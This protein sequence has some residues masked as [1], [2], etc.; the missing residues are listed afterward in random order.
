M[1]VRNFLLFLSELASS[2][3]WCHL[4]SRYYCLPSFYPLL[5]MAST[6]VI[7]GNMLKAGY[8]VNIQKHFSRVRE[9]NL[10]NNPSTIHKTNLITHRK[11]HVFLIT[12]AAFSDSTVM[13][14]WCNQLQCKRSGR[15]I[16]WLLPLI[17]TVGWSLQR[18]TA[19]REQYTDCHRDFP[20]CIFV[21]E[22]DT[23]FSYQSTVFPSSCQKIIFS[24]LCLGV[25]QVR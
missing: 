17:R 23:I 15:K 12:I 11:S 9:R 2:L 7:Y 13:L 14:C 22:E 5:F 25:L 24:W 20:P 18:W 4:A 21:L 8:G 19:I 3:W 6:M 16:F 1:H 10:L